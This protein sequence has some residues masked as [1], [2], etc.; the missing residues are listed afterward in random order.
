MIKKTI[1]Y[2]ELI[3]IHVYSVILLREEPCV[4]IYIIHCTYIV[5]YTVSSY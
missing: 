5:Q 3:C 2:I 1:V 4:L